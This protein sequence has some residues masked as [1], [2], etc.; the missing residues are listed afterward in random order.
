MKDMPADAWSQKYDSVLGSLRDK[1]RIPNSDRLFAVKAGLKM[2]MTPDEIFH[3]SK[4][5][6]WFI[7][8]IEELV[9]F[10]KYFA[11]KNKPAWL[12]RMR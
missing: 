3:L 4:I 11:F 12:K 7:A 1:I 6:P 2:G 9:N 8:Q 5:D 10:E